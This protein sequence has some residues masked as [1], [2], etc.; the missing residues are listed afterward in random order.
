MSLRQVEIESRILEPFVLPHTS[1]EEEARLLRQFEQSVPKRYGTAL[2]VGRFQPVH[3]GH[4]ML[5]KHALSVAGRLIVGIGSS[6]IIDDDNP[7]SLEQRQRM[8]TRVFER[9]KGVHRQIQRIVPLP[10]VPDDRQWL[11]ETIAAVGGTVDTVLSNND[12]VNGIFR[13]AKYPVIETPLYF[14][15]IYEGKKIREKLR[16]MK[17]L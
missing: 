1:G 15:E 5:M 3:Y 10:D 14:R 16:G 13:K 9:E 4:V 17:V 6:N 12:W 8:L 2:V 11:V 7:F